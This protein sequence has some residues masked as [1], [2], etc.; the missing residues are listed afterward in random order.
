MSSKR[1]RVTFYVDGKQHEIYAPPWFKP[2]WK[3]FKEICKRDGQSVSEVIQVWVDGYVRRK[4][5][6]NPQRPLTAWVEGHEDEEARQTQEIYAWLY[7]YADKRG[8]EL[9]YKFIVNNLYGT[10]VPPPRRPSM[11]DDLA[12]RLTKAGIAVLR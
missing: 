3:K 1:T 6:G 10:G 11:A 2:T 8:G 7:E 5:P 12:M 4:D 9:T